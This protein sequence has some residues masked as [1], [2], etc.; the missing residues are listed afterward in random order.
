MNIEVRM[1]ISQGR[2]I[3]GESPYYLPALDKAFMRP[4]PTKLE[5]H[6]RPRPALRFDRMAWPELW[7]PPRLELLRSPA[8][9]ATLAGE[10]SSSASDG[11]S[12]ASGVWDRTYREYERGAC[13]LAGTSSDDA[14]HSTILVG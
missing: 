7:P 5:M 13:V 4:S 14:R 11:Y 3:C 8:L 12:R 10:R 9:L 2:V 1:Y 6:G